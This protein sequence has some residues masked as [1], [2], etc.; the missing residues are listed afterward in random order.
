VLGKLPR[1]AMGMTLVFVYMTTC[2]LYVEG[3][4]FATVGSSVRSG[5]KEAPG[6]GVSR[7]GPELEVALGLLSPLARNRVQS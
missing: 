2:P 3:T 7:T 4:I 1:S 5:G 6:P